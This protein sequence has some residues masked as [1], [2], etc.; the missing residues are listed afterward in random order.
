MK[1]RTIS[2]SQR[3]FAAQFSTSAAERVAEKPVS[4]SRWAQP[5]ESSSDTK[6][7]PDGAGEEAL[8]TQGA[9]QSCVGREKDDRPSGEPQDDQGGAS[10]DGSPS[11][12]RAPVG[13]NGEGEG[14]KAKDNPKALGQSS[15]STGRK[16]RESKRSGDD[17]D[18]EQTNDGIT[19]T[20]LK[21]TQ[22]A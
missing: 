15:V 8:L 16:C 12:H 11:V 7:S 10:G 13:G 3:N 17:S 22:E 19:L 14:K 5:P 20:L 4:G 9:G 6:P 2:D 1:V 21:R 18:D